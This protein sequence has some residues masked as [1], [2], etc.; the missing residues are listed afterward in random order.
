MP[1][2]FA[3]LTWS[4]RVLPGSVV[5]RPRDGSPTAWTG[6]DGGHRG[7][8]RAPCSCGVGR[9]GAVC[10]LAGAH[11][12]VL[13]VVGG[14]TRPV[15][16]HSS[17]VR[18]RH[19]RCSPRRRGRV[20]TLGGAGHWGRRVTCRPCRSTDPKVRCRPTSR[21]PSLSRPWTRVVVV[22]HEAPH[23]TS[24]TEGSSC[25]H[26]STGVGRFPIWPAAQRPCHARDPPLL[27]T[28]ITMHRRSPAK[29][30]QLARSARVDDMRHSAAKDR[31]F[32]T[33]RPN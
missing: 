22:V 6:P 20:T 26:P 9:P 1:S 8:L 10:S 11:S 2:A 17:R 3:T 16:G 29:S 19:R 31:T 21:F 7:S 33:V 32:K 23:M 25:G 30:P 18:A 14:A 24:P 4:A 5:A 28:C 13:S 12:G 15:L 27:P